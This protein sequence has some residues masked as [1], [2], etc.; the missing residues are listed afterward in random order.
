MARP[1]KLYAGGPVDWQIDDYLLMTSG[2]RPVSAEKDWIYL[3]D[4]VQ[5]F[6]R[7]NPGKSYPGSPSQTDAWQT[8]E[9][10]EDPDPVRRLGGVPAWKMNF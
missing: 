10:L 9:D 2:L 4:W 5:R 7:H 8:I 3:G 6:R 1:R